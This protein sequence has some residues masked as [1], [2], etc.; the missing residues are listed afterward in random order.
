M[1]IDG[2]RE[3]LDGKRLICGKGYKKVTFLCTIDSFIMVNGVLFTM[4]AGLFTI[5]GKFVYHR[6][7]EAAFFYICLVEGVRYSIQF[8][9]A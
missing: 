9:N 6:I 2:E 5:E 8:Y 3:K 4:M 1:E 7:L